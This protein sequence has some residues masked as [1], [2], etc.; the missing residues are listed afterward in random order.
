[1]R[2]LN[3]AGLM[4]LLFAGGDP[5]AEPA[6]EQG[7]DTGRL[8]Y[9]W[10]KGFDRGLASV[11]EWRWLDPQTADTELTLED[12]SFEFGEYGGYLSLESVTYGDLTGDGE[13]EAAIDLVRSPGGTANWHYLYVF[14]FS[15]GADPTVLGILRSGSRASGGLAGVEIVDGALRLEFN[16]P[17]F[18]RSDCCSEGYILATYAYDGTGF[19][20]IAPRVRGLREETE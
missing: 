16:D 14:Q 8:V 7:L 19:S 9:P 5:S 15:P 6:Q 17:E 12:G 20:E 10:S 3:L 13:A 2:L 4:V 11:S 1:M 18:Q